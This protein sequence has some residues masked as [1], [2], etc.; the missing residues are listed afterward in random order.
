MRLLG[1]EKN[2]IAV[3]CRTTLRVRRYIGGVSVQVWHWGRRKARKRDVR[4]EYTSVEI[5]RRDEM[6]LFAH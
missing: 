4:S 5:V 2:G 3:V 6:S 1:E